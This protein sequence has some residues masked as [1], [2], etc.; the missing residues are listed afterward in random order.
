MNTEKSKKSVKTATKRESKRKKKERILII[1]DEPSF[2]EACRRTLEAK[3]YRITTASSKTQAQEVIKKEPSLIILGTMAPAGQ[4]FATY[5][6]LGE[7]P[8]YK[9]IPLLVIDARY[10]ERRTGLD[11]HR[12]G[13]AKRRFPSMERSVYDFDEGEGQGLRHGLTRPE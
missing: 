5:Q 2:V 12:L 9:D 6:W 7:N 8:R 11:H 3:A 4:A 13:R 1:D 10:E